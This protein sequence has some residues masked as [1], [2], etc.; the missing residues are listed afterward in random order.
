MSSSLAE[1][2]K[3]LANT[4]KHPNAHNAILSRARRLLLRLVGF[5]RVGSFICLSGQSQSGVILGKGMRVLAPYSIILPRA[6][7]DGLQASISGGR[8][9]QSGR[10][11]TG[12]LLVAH[13]GFRIASSAARA[14]N[15]DRVSPCLRAWAST[16]RRIRCGKVMLILAA[17]S[18]SSLTSTSTIAQVQPR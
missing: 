15:P 17:L 6:K 13:A 5:G 4:N 12:N 14:R 1:V 11:A 2:L 18:P 3:K 7:N 9:S 10:S 8:M 16:A